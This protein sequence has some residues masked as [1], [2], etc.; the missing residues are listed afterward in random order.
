M[1]SV[2]F[3][4]TLELFYPTFFG[5]YFGTSSQ[6]IC[7]GY[8]S[9]LEDKKIVSEV[10]N[11][12]QLSYLLQKMVGKSFLY[13]QEGTLHSEEW[14]DLSISFRLEKERPFLFHLQGILYRER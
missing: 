10:M 14:F 13:S 8:W 11:L 3:I 1:D 4:L 9:E 6:M 5:F 12:S 2:Q 7:L